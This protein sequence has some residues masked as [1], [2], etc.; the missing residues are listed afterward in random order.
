[1]ST[2]K[3]IYLDPGHGGSDPGAV[4]GKR[5]ESDD[6]LRLALL[7]K[8]K[9]KE[10]GIS[11]VMARESDTYVGLNVRCRDANNAKCDYYLSIHRNSGSPSSNGAECWI[12]SEPSERVRRFGKLLNDAVVNSA[13]FYNRGVKL[14][15]PAAKGYK[16]FGINRLTKMPS[17]LLEI[18]FITNDGDNALFDKNSD[19]IASAL[20][21]ALC[22]I[23]GVPYNGANTP[24][25]SPKPEPPKPVTPSDNSPKHEIS[26]EDTVIVNGIG[27]SSSS[28]GGKKS[29]EFKN[30]KMRVVKISETGSNKFACSIILNKGD[31]GVTAWFS[32]SQLSQV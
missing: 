1:M 26:P 4:S 31:K 11:V 6:T 24:E 15:T 23:V 29:R 9:L 7:V 3:K 21:K 20:T 16:D 28:G 19:N 32:Q 10:Q 14:G 5:R 17:A 13:S 30:Q 2:K 27:T 12:H 22:E 18:G 25:A 8:K